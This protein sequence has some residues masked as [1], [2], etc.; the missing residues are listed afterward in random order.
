MD[1]RTAAP[2]LERD[3]DRYR[4]ISPAPIEEVIA[5]PHGVAFLKW[6]ELWNVTLETETVEKIA[7][8][9][10][11]H[12]LAS[13]ERTLYWLGRFGNGRYSYRTGEQGEL[14]TFAGLGRQNGLVVGDA[15]YGLAENGAVWRIG[16]R[17]NHRVN[18]PRENWQSG[19]RILAGDEVVM[20]PVFD[21]VEVAYY[22]WRVVGKKGER[23]EIDMPCVECVA[24]DAQGRLLFVRE[25]EVKILGPRSKTPKTLFET[26]DTSALCWCGRDICT[27]SEEAGELRHHKRTRS[28]YT[29]VATDIGPAALLSCNKKYVTWRGIADD[30]PT[31]HVVPLGPGRK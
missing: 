21:N 25:G 22:Y 31:V 24:V 3:G 23:L 19:A 20:F 13:D 7:F 15:P 5:T 16:K 27:A 8:A 6:G 2:T 11:L 26:S 4:V 29:V 17:H 9:T 1:P 30:Q 12:A 28:D 10:D 18:A 14:R